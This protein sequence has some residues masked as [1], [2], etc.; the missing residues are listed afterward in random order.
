MWVKSAALARRELKQQG[1]RSSKQAGSA[2]IVSLCKAGQLEDAAQIYEDMMGTSAAPAPGLLHAQAARAGPGC[3]VQPVAPHDLAA[4]SA[5]S[6]SG[7]SSQ[8]L[9]ARGVAEGARDPPAPE[10]I[11]LD[12][13]AAAAHQEHGDGEAPAR[14]QADNAPGTAGRQEPGEAA[15]ASSLA[16]SPQQGAVLAKRSMQPT[17]EAVA[18]LVHTCAAAGNVQQCWR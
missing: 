1:S 14:G 2:L 17:S 9:L 15:S 5:P 7:G 11:G 18:Y 6:L 3:E 8:V 4:G 10:Q 12:M 16:A 13:V